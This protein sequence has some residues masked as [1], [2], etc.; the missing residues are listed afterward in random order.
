[1]PWSAAIAAVGAIGGGLISSNAAGAAANSQQRATDAAMAE[2]RREFD[3]NQGNQQPYLDAGRTA[4]GQYQTDIGKP[5]TAADVM[6]DP[7]YQ[8]G[9]NQGQ[10]GLDRKTAAMGGRV[11][12]AAL[13]AADRYA[14]DYASTGYNSAYQRG[15]D[16]L[17]RLA[18]L[19]GLGQ[20]A[21]Q[22]SAASGLAST[23][24]ISNLLTNQGDARAAGQLA[25]GSI[26]GNALGQVAGLAG[27]SFGGGGGMSGMNSGNSYYSGGNRYSN[28]DLSGTNRGSGD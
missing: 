21:T 2:Q 28:F 26:W 20:T 22:A 23:N 9:L 24:A 8:F 4:L 13:K 19:A 5:I 17:N 16:R 18:S 10:L 7:G 1:M 25:Q 14:T 15:Q 11:S 3:I 6:S 27:N 12:G